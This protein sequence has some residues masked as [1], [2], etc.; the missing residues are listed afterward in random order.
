MN[1]I[2]KTLDPEPKKNLISP[3]LPTHKTGEK[4]KSLPY[5]HLFG[6]VLMVWNQLKIKCRMEGA[7]P[8]YYFHTSAPTES[9]FHL[10]GNIVS[11]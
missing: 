2:L 1:R 5:T 9:Y 11:F 10:N 4:L 3:N 7:D 8:L 6:V